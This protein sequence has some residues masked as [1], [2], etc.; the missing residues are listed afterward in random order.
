MIP[1]APPDPDEARSE[2]LEELAKPEYRQGEGFVDWL[3][4]TL[5]EWLAQ[6]M[7]GIGAS[8]AAQGVLTVLAV[9]LLVLAAVLVARRTGWLRRSAALRVDASLTAAAR[10]SGSELRER[11]RE[12]IDAGRH[13]DGAVLA[14]RALVRDLEERTLL[15]VTDGMT[16]H[17]AATAAA[18]PY[19]DLRPR[20]LRGAA[21]FD[22]AAYS[23]RAVRPKQSEDLLRLAEYVAESS[24]DLGALATTGE[25]P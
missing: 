11:A 24:P 7:D 23:V 6:L 25:A 2:V 3:L 8:P 5:E 1:T 14:L 4:R 20:L 22:T 18:R 21:A 17:E 12:A 9:L 15:E 10:A 16:A 19:P 13:D